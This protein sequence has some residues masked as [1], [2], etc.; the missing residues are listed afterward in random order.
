M[1]VEEV[2]AANPASSQRARTSRRT[3]EYLRASRIEQA[4]RAAL[5]RCRQKEEEEEEEA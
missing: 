3:E 5:M 4:D 2:D 1:Q